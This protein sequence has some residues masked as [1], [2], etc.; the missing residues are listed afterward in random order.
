MLCDQGISYIWFSGHPSRPQGNQP[1]YHPQ[2]QQQ[3]DSGFNLG[4]SSS[5]N[6]MQSPLIA[7]SAQQ[8]QVC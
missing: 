3:G 1:P 5:G 8:H 6:V 4:Q 2:Q 7:A